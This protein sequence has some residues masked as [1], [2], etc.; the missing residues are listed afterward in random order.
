[1]M[2]G[3]DRKVFLMIL[4]VGLICCSVAQGRLSIGSNL[5]DFSA[6]DTAGERFTIDDLIGHPTLIIYLRADHERSENLLFDSS[7]WVEL[8]GILD[9]VAISNEPIQ[10]SYNFPNDIRILLD[11]DREIYGA[12]KIRVL[13]TAVFV[14]EKGIVQSIFKG[15]GLNTGDKILAEITTFTGIGQ[16]IAATPTEDEFSGI[17]DA[18]IRHY[19]L[20]NKLWD[21]GFQDRAREQW[22]LSI[23]KDPSFTLPWIS[24]TR[25]YLA[26][27]D[28][29]SAKS[30]VDNAMK[31][32]ISYEALI[33]SARCNII[34]GNL[35]N[36]EE[37]LEAALDINRM[38][39][40]AK[41]GLA[42]VYLGYGEIADATSLVNEVLLM[43]KTNSRA[44]YLLGRAA[45]LQGDIAK[46][47]ELFKMALEIIFKTQ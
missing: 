46:A 33:L 23:E 44:Y 16:P 28:V 37:N 43:E 30:K 35:E 31:I 1:M 26:L 34:L 12:W 6:S 22:E 38:S 4:T 3:Q 17:E 40:E 39:I 8:I 24:L 14:D 45:E 10:G 36:A 2:R 41:L 25:F 32:A 18:S 29:S 20:G 42:E 11:T 13:P 47:N 27:D 19:R 21:E 9:I 15:Y 5:S 7:Q